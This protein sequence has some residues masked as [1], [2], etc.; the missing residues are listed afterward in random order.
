MLTKLLLLASLPLLLRDGWWWPGKWS[1]NGLVLA[2]CDCAVVAEGA[3]ETERF[4]RGARGAAVVEFDVGVGRLR[5]LARGVEVN[6]GGG[7]LVRCSPSRG[8][9]SGLCV[10]LIESKNIFSAAM[11][12]AGRSWRSFLAA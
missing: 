4:V 3:K 10:I 11:H 7:E 5:A 6:S 1:S 2:D 9:C 8:D 12:E